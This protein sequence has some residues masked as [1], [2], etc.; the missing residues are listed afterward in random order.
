MF[1]S[2]QQSFT[3]ISAVRKR[4]ILLS[5]ALQPGTKGLNLC[6]RRVEDGAILSLCSDIFSQ[7]WKK[8]KKDSDHIKLG[9]EVLLEKLTV[10]YLL[11]KF[12]AY[13]GTEILHHTHKSLP[14]DPNLSQLN[15]VLS[16]ILLGLK[17]HF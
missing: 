17:T 6:K 10:T 1:Y 7:V 3:N 2:L 15:L 4:L 12:P 14:V 16:H 13:C 11:N 9:R 5:I 8:K